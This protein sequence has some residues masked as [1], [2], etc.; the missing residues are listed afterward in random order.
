MSSLISG[1]MVTQCHSGAEL[2]QRLIA[3]GCHGSS[4]IADSDGGRVVGSFVNGRDGV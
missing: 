4:P 3:S 1:R 2:G